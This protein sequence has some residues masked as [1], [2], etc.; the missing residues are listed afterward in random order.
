MNAGPQQ[1]P[2][3]ALRPVHT[4][5]GQLSLATSYYADTDGHGAVT[6]PEGSHATTRANI[7]EAIARDVGAYRQK[8]ATKS[9]F[10]T[11]NMRMLATFA[12]Q[13]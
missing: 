13:Q 7:T 3:S 6:G 9:N 10:P 2:S 4:T 1:G 12:I 5:R 11:E 8:L